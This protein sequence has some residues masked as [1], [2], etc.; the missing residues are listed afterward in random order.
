MCDSTPP[1]YQYAIRA[2]GAIVFI[3]GLI[4]F[5]FSIEVYTF[6]ENVKVGGWWA[7]LLVMVTGI[8]GAIGLNKGFSVSSMI[9]AILGFILCIIASIVDSIASAIVSSLVTC[10][11]NDSNELWGEQSDEQVS[12]ARGCAI[13]SNEDCSCVAGNPKTCYWY[14]PTNAD[15]GEVLTTYDSLLGRA[16]I[17]HIVGIIACLVFSIFLCTSVCCAPAVQV[18]VVEPLPTMSTQVQPGQQVVY[19]TPQQAVAGVVVGV[20]QPD[21]PVPV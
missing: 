15:C 1:A 20:Q 5:I 14:T 17:M 13:L 3:L 19:Q 10:A 9:F 12:A 2:G 11:A 8:F 4:Q 6:M 16:Y 18:A 21:K 7:A